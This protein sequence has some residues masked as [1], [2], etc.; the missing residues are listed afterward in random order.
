MNNL[1]LLSTSTDASAE[2]APRVERSLTSSRFLH[3]VPTT[4]HQIETKPAVTVTASKPILPVSVA[5]IEH[6]TSQIEI[7]KVV[8]VPV[9]V[10]IKGDIT[11]DGQASIVVCGRV[12][13]NID[14]GDRSVLV[15]SGGEVLGTIKA[16]DAVVV[17]GTVTAASDETPAVVTAGLW[18]LAETAKVKGTVAY[19]RHRAYEGGSFTG[20]A[21]PFADFKLTK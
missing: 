13:G 16:A 18:I 14:A 15:K 5:D 2:S 3:E 1:A 6:F 19:G 21:V 20:R 7:D 4:V 12:E 9:G 10:T 8:L 17:A 11:T